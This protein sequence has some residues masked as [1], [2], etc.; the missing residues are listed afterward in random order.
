M[1]VLEKQKDIQVMKAMGASNRLIQKIFLSEGSLLAFIGM[2][3]GIVLALLFCWAQV[4]FK[5]ITIPGATFLI[6]HYPVQLEA[7]D[8]VLVILTVAIV[9]LLASWFP[10]RKAALQPIELKS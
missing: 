4:K 10:S 6:D 2:T 8:F 3:S 9:A 7:S 1:L 5:L